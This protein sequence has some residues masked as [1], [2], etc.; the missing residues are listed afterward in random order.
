MNGNCLCKTK[1]K[2]RKK[3]WCDHSKTKQAETMK[4]GIIRAHCW[5]LTALNKNMVEKWC[6]CFNPGAENVSLTC[7]WVLALFQACSVHSVNTTDKPQTVQQHLSFKR[8]ES[9]QSF[10]F[11]V[12]RP[13]RCISHPSFINML[14]NMRTAARMLLWTSGTKKKKNQQ[15]KMYFRLKMA[16]QNVRPLQLGL[17]VLPIGPGWYNACVRTRVRA[18]LCPN[19]WLFGRL[20]QI[21]CGH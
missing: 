8:P 1:K 12:K 6:P 21:H 17:K 4:N 10:K 16:M 7:M 19:R 5:N 9:T 11:K 18:P 14:E 15:L 20:D 2:N 13:V 3:R